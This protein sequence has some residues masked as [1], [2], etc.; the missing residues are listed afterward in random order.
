MSATPTDRPV[1]LLVMSDLVL[2]SRID[3]I[4]RRTGLS[5]RAAKSAEQLER[6][7]A[8]GPE[9][10]AVIVDLE[11]D[12]IDP[13]ATIERLRNRPGGTDL[14]IIGYSGHTN[15]EAI[16]AGRAAGAG[17]VLARSALADRLPSLLAPLA[18]EGPQPP[19]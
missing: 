9:P 14:P 11:C 12:T 7:L 19:G 6:H 15:A 8:N 1:V 13:F 5:L 18:P 16:R 17:R 10:T 3:D 2:R 4:A